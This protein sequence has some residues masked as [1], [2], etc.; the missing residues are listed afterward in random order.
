MK[1]RGGV[2][3]AH[4]SVGS[5]Q[6]GMETIKIPVSAGWGDPKTNPHHKNSRIKVGAP[7]SS[8]DSC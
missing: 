4:A 5:A 3:R 7:E 8:H 1:L 2:E 6:L